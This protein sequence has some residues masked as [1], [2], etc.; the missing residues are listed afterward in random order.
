M[1]SEF[2]GALTKPFFNRY[3]NS[4]IVSNKIILQF[5]NASVSL[6]IVISVYSQTQYVIFSETLLTNPQWS[7]HTK[8]NYPL[9]THLIIIFI[10]HI[11]NPGGFIFRLKLYQGLTT[12]R[13]F[14]GTG[15]RV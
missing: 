12:W 14:F 7:N 2:M 10:I 3:G 9:P 1:V 8:L 13:G 4:Y 6:D 15:L 5:Q 11:T